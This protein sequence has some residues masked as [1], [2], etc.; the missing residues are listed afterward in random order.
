M[1]NKLVCL[2]LC[3]C[4]ILALCSCTNRNVEKDSY[5]IDGTWIAEKEFDG[6]IYNEEW[7]FDYDNINFTHSTRRGQ[8]YNSEDKFNFETRLEDGKHIIKIDYDRLDAFVEWEYKVED[9][10]LYLMKDG[11]VH[12]TLEKEGV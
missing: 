1:K 5:N 12:Y 3:V 6:E 11:Q 9:N 4:S 7:S 10:T 8:G 2:I